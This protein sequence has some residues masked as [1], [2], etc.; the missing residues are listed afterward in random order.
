MK[1]KKDSLSLRRSEVKEEM[2]ARRNAMLIMKE[3]ARKVGSGD[4]ALY[5]PFERKGNLKKV[6]GLTNHATDH[7][8]P[9]LKYAL[10]KGCRATNHRKGVSV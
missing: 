3:L 2:K 7:A 9:I 8:R 10:L 6:R 4:V 1:K 5:I